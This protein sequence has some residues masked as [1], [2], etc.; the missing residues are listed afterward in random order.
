MVGSLVA[1]PASAHYAVT[2]VGRERTLI[3]GVLV[4]V[5]IAALV[6]G[7]IYLTVEARSLP[8]ILGTLHN[9]HGHR[10]ARGLGLLIVGFVLLIAGGALE[11]F[12]RPR[13]FA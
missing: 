12:A 5:G 13:G 7:I 9:A 10:S 11:R 2:H 3:A 1:P 8:S 6:V 4:L